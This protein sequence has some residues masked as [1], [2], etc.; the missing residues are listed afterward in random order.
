MDVTVYV[1][2]CGTTACF[3][4]CLDLLPHQISAMAHITSILQMCCGYAE[5]RPAQQEAYKQLK[6][7]LDKVTYLQRKL[8]SQKRRRSRSRGVR[9]MP[10]ILSS[11]HGHGTQESELEGSVLEGAALASLPVS[12]L[13]PEEKRDEKSAQ[14][15]SDV[16]QEIRP[17]TQVLNSVMNSVEP[18]QPVDQDDHPDVADLALE[19]RDESGSQ[20]G[21][22]L[23]IGSFDGSVDLENL[24]GAMPSLEDVPHS[25]PEHEVNLM[26]LDEP[27]K[28]SSSATALVTRL[29]RE[30]TDPEPVKPKK[31]KAGTLGG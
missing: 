10:A 21:R 5:T 4:L 6:A 30:D 16:E 12:M 13:S 2:T 25:P 31:K 24:P 11:G 18:Q 26:S 15:D 17:L 14:E 7:H 1:Q 22:E 8:L 23:S 29:V 19:S 27:P 28:R 9:V 3:A 20:L